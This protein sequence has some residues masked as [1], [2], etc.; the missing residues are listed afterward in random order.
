MV[1]PPGAGQADV[2]HRVATEHARPATDRLGEPLL[3]RPALRDRR[4]RVEDAGRRAARRVPAVAVGQGVGLRAV[5]RHGPAPDGRPG[6]LSP[7]GGALPRRADR[8]PRSPE[9]PR[10]L[11]DARRA[12]RSGQTIL[13][14]THY[15]EEA[16]RCAT[17]WRSWT[18]A[19]SSPSTRRRTEAGVGA[20]TIVTVGTDRR[21]RPAAEAAGRGAG[22]SRTRDIDGAIQLHMQG[23]ERMVPRIVKAAEHGGFE[24]VDLAVAEPSLETVFINLTGKELREA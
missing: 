10:A 24:I 9:P 19:G 18:T 17:G 6:D 22:V 23:S 20:D 2:G 11:G 12:Q 7:P 13:L 4:A 3:P 1:G 14:T 16:D 5:R 15:M 21:P 8:G